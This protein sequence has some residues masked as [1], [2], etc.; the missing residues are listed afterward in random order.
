MQA[1]HTLALLPF[2]FESS[3]L[4]IVYQGE[5][6]WTNQFGYDD[7]KPLLTNCHGASPCSRHCKWADGAHRWLLH[8]FSIVSQS[9]DRFSRRLLLPQTLSS[10]DTP[11]SRVII[12][13]LHLQQNNT[14]K[15]LL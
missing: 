15:L 2:L 1:E 10:Y 6:A 14:Q 9:C 8:G 4:L 13:H 12:F 5:Y 11:V 3:R 7:Y